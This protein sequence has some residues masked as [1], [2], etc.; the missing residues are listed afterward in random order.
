MAVPGRRI[1][2]PWIAATAGGLP[3]RV[4]LTHPRRIDEH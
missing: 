3:V 4:H 2:V 1:L